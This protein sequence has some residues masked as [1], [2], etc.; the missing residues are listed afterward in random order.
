MSDVP[1]EGYNR[2]LSAAA[3]TA[4]WIKVV[5][6][7]V[8]PHAESAAG[9]ESLAGAESVAGP[10][11][12]A[13]W[14][15]E[16]P[17][18]EGQLQAAETPVCSKWISASPMLWHKVDEAN[19]A[20]DQ[21]QAAEGQPQAA[22]SSASDPNATYQ[23][24]NVAKFSGVQSELVGYT[25]AKVAYCSGEAEQGP[26][27]FAHT[28][29]AVGD[30]ELVVEVARLSATQDAHDAADDAK[31]PS[32]RGDDASM[33]ATG[34]Y[35]AQMEMVERQYCRTMKNLI[36]S[37]NEEEFLAYHNGSAVV[38]AAKVAEARRQ[39]AAAELDERCRTQRSQNSAAEV[40]EEEEENAEAV[41][42]QVQRWRITQGL[43]ATGGLAES[44]TGGETEPAAEAVTAETE[45]VERVVAAARRRRE[46]ASA[47]AVTAETAEEADDDGTRPPFGVYKCH[48][49]GCKWPCTLRK[50]C[51]HC[52]NDPTYGEDLHPQ[53]DN[54]VKDV[55]R[56]A[57]AV[58]MEAAP[59]V[60]MEV[61]EEQ[62]DLE[63]C[64]RDPSFRGYMDCV[65]SEHPRLA[66]PVG[67][68][69]CAQ[70]CFSMVDFERSPTTPPRKATISYIA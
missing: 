32:P 58:Q 49:C 4:S 63:T 8:Q 7:S 34:G 13:E 28:A 54:D 55:P 57:P 41:K 64:F 14:T 22:R 36:N 27:A 2:S 12:I 67:Y 10:K 61:K 56:A 40:E 9:A 42:A 53:G 25:Y 30:A 3:E 26:R 31:C 51:S 50:E 33:P 39:A 21:S 23:Q 66:Q 45:R 47:E 69:D 20:R 35:K 6:D 59:S 65:P 18:V 48:T 16:D 38:V 29:L 43:P 62:P 15:I 60:K 19:D 46:R 70:S 24:V 5:E 1:S 68:S 44:V 17:R 11:T 37:M 52:G